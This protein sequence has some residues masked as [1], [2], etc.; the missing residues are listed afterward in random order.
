MRYPR[1]SITVAQACFPVH[2]SRL[3]AAFN[4]FETI[5]F[6]SIMKTTSF[7]HPLALAGA[8]FLSAVSLC[9]Q[10]QQPAQIQQPLAAQMAGQYA[11]Q[12]QVADAGTQAGK[13]FGAPYAP[14]GQVGPQQAQI[15]YFR[16]PASGA[17]A[18]VAANVYVDGEFQTALKPYGYTVF[19][20]K[21]GEH[22]L[23]AYL[24]D[25]PLY[26][27]KSTDRFSGNLKGGMTYFLTMRDG[28]TGVPQALPRADAERELQGMRAQVHALS[29]ASTVVACQTTPLPAAPVAQHKDYTLKGDM[30]FAFGKSGYRDMSAR[31]REEIGRLV[32][33]IRQENTTMGKIQ[34]I[35]HADQIGSDND[36]QRLG[37]QRAL[38]VRR[39]LIERGIPAAQV[40]AESAGNTEPIVDECNGS[41]QQMIECYAPNRR[42]VV[43]VDMRRPA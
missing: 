25:A 41:R 19:C 30:L 23:G 8:A 42:V 12:M 7:L 15:V 34:V 3:E 20:V 16:G 35:G 10:A 39:M 11:P 43:R 27:G 4:G 33:Q 14:V 36:A 17:D 24:R 5:P 38:T 9:A 22:T 31:G 37:Q 18:R 2:V 28:N 6:I 13:V 21:P 32:A 29:R 1:R 40:E 26:K